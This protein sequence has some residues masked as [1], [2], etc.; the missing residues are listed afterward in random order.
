MTA[1]KTLVINGEALLRLK[2]NGAPEGV[3]DSLRASAD[4]LLSSEPITV[5]KRKLMPPTKNKK[6]YASTGIYW[7]PNP[8]TEDGLPYVRRD[9]EIN[10]ETKDNQSIESLADRM[11]VLAL[12]SFYFGDE[13][14]KAAA[15]EQLRVFYLDEKLGM[16]PHGEFAQGIPGI[17][18]GRGI[19][20]IEYRDNIS[21]IDAI[22]ILESIGALT[23]EDSS[24]LRSWFVR[25]TDWMITSEK[26]IDEDN[27]HNNHGAWYDAQIIAMA[28]FTGRKQ[29]AKRVVRTSYEQRQIRH[30]KQDGSQPHELAR[31]KAM[32]YSLFNTTALATV[33]ILS[34]RLDDKRYINDGL[35]ARSFDYIYRYVKDP[36]SF[37]YTELAPGQ[38]DSASCRAALMLDLIYPDGKYADTVKDRLSDDMYFRL[39]PF[40]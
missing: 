29:L 16:N 28:L 3:L 40:G 11:T 1:P 17:C 6:D 24:E 23:D 36:K 20:L 34:S 7:W 5:T 37:P 22:L 8:D 2:Q 33:A 39:T 14:Y 26:G 12:A 25:L 19:G 9:G 30:I 31:T 13:C 32:M 38:L 4:K 21:V 35:I 10:P 18:E 27:Q 15:R